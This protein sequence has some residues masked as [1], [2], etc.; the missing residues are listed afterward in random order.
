MRDGIICGHHYVEL[1]LM[2]G[3]NLSHIANRKV[4]LD[5]SALRFDFRPGD[6]S[7]GQVAGGHEKAMLR[8]ANG[9]RADAA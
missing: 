1:T 6:C 3:M 2:M 8:Q 4:D 7:M 5:A 9:L